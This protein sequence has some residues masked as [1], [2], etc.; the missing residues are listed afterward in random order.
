MDNQ[1]QAPQKNPSSIWKIV[2]VLVILALLF[3]LNGMRNIVGGAFST[4]FIA[5]LVIGGIFLVLIIIDAISPKDKDGNKNYNWVGYVILAGLVA[6]YI[7]YHNEQ[8][9]NKNFWHHDYVYW[10]ESSTQD[11]YQINEV[12]SW[13]DCDTRASSDRFA[14]Y[15]GW[16]KCGKKCKIPRG[17]YGKNEPTCEEVKSI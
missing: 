4:I 2:G 13:Q 8:Q 12:S 3:G 6:W 16:I 9:E 10:R 7:N 1:G 15:S 17:N 11:G 14:L 5:L